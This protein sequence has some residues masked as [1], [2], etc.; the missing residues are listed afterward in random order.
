M[1]GLLQI[2]R[3]YIN[4]YLF[5]NWLPFEFF[6]HFNSFYFLPS[7]FQ[8]YIPVFFY[9]HIFISK[10]LPFAF[11]II[12]VFPLTKF[13]CLLCSG[14]VISAWVL[15]KLLSLRNLHKLTSDT[16][17]C[18]YICVQR[19]WSKLFLLCFVCFISFIKI[20]FTYHKIYPF[21]VYNSVVF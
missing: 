6:Y 12:I 15:K 14:T 21:K 8:P 2:Y 5:W 17:L 11:G 19:A 10:S 16:N 7:L 1:T 4:F 3:K 18:F 20:L 9:I 13:K